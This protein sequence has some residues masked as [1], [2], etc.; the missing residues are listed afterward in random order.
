MALSIR[1]DPVEKFT[2]ASLRADLS[3]PEQRQAA[4]QF[5]RDGLED[6]K[7][8]N[9]SILGRVPPYTTTVDGR[10]DAQLES[11]NPDGGSIIFEFDVGVVDALQWIARALVERS[12]V[13]SGQYKRGHKL[14]ADGSETSWPA[15]GGNIPPAT[16]YTFINLVPY[17]RKIEIGKTRAGRAFVIQVPNRI[18]ERTAIDARKEKFGSSADIQFAYRQAVGA[19][20]LKHSSGRRKD[21]QRGAAVGTPAIIVKFKRA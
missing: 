14:L 19:Y 17:A 11:V 15:G 4:A 12:P 13:V 2:E 7:K 6:A 5:A 18:Y 3:L 8:T 16:E 21:R 20:T 10:K 1:I 9:R